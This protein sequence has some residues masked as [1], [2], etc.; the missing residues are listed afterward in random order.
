MHRDVNA[1]T[2]SKRKFRTP[3]RFRSYYYYYHIY[4]T[5]HFCKIRRLPIKC[6]STINIHKFY[7][8]QTLFK[9]LRDKK[10]LHRGFFLVLFIRFRVSLLV[11]NAPHAGSPLI[12]DAYYYIYN[13]FILYTIPFEST[14]EKLVFSLLSLFILEIY[15]RSV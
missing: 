14:V 6:K 15:Q 2:L 8:T 1:V 3:V 13:M 5:V 10:I 12:H 4:L 11:S 7:F 9:F